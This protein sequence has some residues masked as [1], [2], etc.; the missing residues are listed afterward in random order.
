M[1]NDAT[2]AISKKIWVT[3]AA[4]VAA[5]K[6][7]TTVFRAYVNTIIA[8]AASAGRKDIVTRVWRDLEP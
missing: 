2:T 4:D 8:T 7:A 6:D 3:D 1:P 5:R